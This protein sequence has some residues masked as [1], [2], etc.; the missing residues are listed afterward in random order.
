MQGIVV[1]VIAF[2]KHR[3][4]LTSITVLFDDL[5]TFTQEALSALTFSIGTSGIEHI[6]ATQTLKQINTK[7]MKTQLIGDIPLL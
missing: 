2:V 3:I 5:Y 6:F 1:H 4:I 7:T